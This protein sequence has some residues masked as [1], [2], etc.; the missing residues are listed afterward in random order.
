MHVR[1]SQITNKREKLNRIERLF[2]ITIVWSMESLIAK[3]IEFYL[4]I[5]LNRQP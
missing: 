5:I 4:H 3:N 2:L 1:F